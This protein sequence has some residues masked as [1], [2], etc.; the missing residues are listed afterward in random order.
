MKKRWMLLALLAW[1]VPC[2]VF[3]DGFTVDRIQVDG[4]RHIS[5]QTVKSYLPIKVGQTFTAQKSDEVINALYATGFFSNVSLARQGNTLIVIVDERPV[6]VNI[7]FSGNHAINSDKLMKA[8][9][10][11]G[12]REGFT[13]DQALIHKI[14]IGLQE[15]YYSMGYYNANVDVQVKKQSRNRVTVHL[16][17]HEGPLAIIRQINVIGNHGFSEKTILKKMSLTTSGMLTWLTHTDRYSREKLN[18]DLRSITAFY[19]N[20]GYLRFHITSSTV[21]LTPDKANV[22]LT[23]HVDEGAKYTV[24]GFTVTGENII[25]TPVLIKAIDLPKG[26]VFSRDRIVSATNVIKES[27]GRKGF[28][29]A[30]VDPLPKIDEKTHTVFINFKVHQGKVVYVHH[31]QFIGNYKTNDSALRPK[32][33][34]VEGGVINTDYVKQ[35]QRQLNQLPYLRNVNIKTVPTEGKDDQVDLKVK[36]DEVPAASLT[37]GVGY[38]TLDGVVLNG[39]LTHKNVFGTG[40][41]FSINLS[42]SGYLQTYSV[43]YINPYYTMDGITRGITAYI[44]RTDPSEANISS[45][46]SFDELGAKVFYNI[47]M[48][49]SATSSNSLNL[50]YGFSSTNLDVSD[51]ASTQINDFVDDY[52]RH[53][54]DLNLSAGWVHN[55]LNRYIFPTKGFEQ[56]LGTNVA[57]PVDSNS[58]GYYKINYQAVNYFSLS[59]SFILKMKGKLGYGSGFIHSDDLPFYR[60][61]FAG[62][63]GS[64]RGYEGNTLGPRDSNDDPFGGNFLMTGTVALIFPNFISPDNLRTSIFVDGGNVYDLEGLTDDDGFSF[65]DLRFGAGLDVQWLSPVGLIEFS[66]AEALNPGS[67]DEEQIFDFRMGVNF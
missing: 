43:S 1:L 58:I 5:S 65:G 24:S 59:R 13:Y 26:S 35:S 50:G 37:A 41:T 12:L 64:V 62:G 22:Y 25:P 10:T 19:M 7:T 51:D 42:H 31:I 9:N 17:V 4:L 16:V 14:K 67:K 33:A 30:S 38:S 2:L 57:L 47:P 15:Q 23:I 27:M 34:Q 56:S 54:N 60:N 28:A 3:A 32:M 45:E 53:F 46:Y 20:H 8:L 52:G 11:M 63:I 29:F 48:S 6:V 66:L 36:M 18:N 21:E 55:G 49:A 44:K 61:Y 40:K 39:A